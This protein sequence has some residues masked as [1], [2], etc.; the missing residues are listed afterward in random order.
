MVSNFIMQAL[1]ILE[2]TEMVKELT[3]SKPEIVFQREGLPRTIEYFRL[4]WCGSEPALISGLFLTAD[5][6]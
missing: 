3:G 4:N 1:T 5:I 2:L 6:P